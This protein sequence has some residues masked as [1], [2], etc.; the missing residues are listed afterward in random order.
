MAN[1]DGIELTDDE[2]QLAEALGIEEYIDFE[3][4]RSCSYCKHKF[5]NIWSLCPKCFKRA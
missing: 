1:I 2:L 5:S 3:E 4:M